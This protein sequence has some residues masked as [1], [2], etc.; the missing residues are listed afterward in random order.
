MVLSVE[1]MKPHIMSKS[2]L[3]WIATSLSLFVGVLAG[4][5]ALRAYQ[6]HRSI[7]DQLRIDVSFQFPE[8]SFDRIPH[9]HIYDSDEMAHN[10]GEPYVYCCHPVTDEI[11]F[12]YH[13]GAGGYTIDGR[14]VMLPDEDPDWVPVWMDSH[15]PEHR[16]VK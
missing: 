9:F 15:A 2:R 14:C 12:K 4:W 5:Y 16:V 6:L 7:P 10:G 1:I 13:E 3:L 8:I 11:G